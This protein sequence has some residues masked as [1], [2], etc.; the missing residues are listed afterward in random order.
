MFQTKGGLLIPDSCRKNVVAECHGLNV[1]ARNGR[2]I[3][4]REDRKNDGTDTKSCTVE[5]A[6]V[7]INAVGT[8]LKRMRSHVGH[9]RQRA[10]VLEDFLHALQEVVKQAQEQGPYENADMRRA[11]LRSAP[12]TVSMASKYEEE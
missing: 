10:K 2:V 3:M 8:Q 12:V 4:E 9:S 1:F 11:R 5:E 6:I 7:R